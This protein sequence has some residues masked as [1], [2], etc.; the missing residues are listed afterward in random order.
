MAKQ[1]FSSPCA[2]D[3]QLDKLQNICNVCKRTIEEIKRWHKL[4]LTERRNILI[5]IKNQENNP[6]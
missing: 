6:T 1:P 2:G 4:T 5:R 3:C